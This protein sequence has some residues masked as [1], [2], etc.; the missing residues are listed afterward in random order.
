VRSKVLDV[1]RPLIRKAARPIVAFLA[2][3]AAGIAGF[4]LL[5]GVTVIE[6]TFWLLD[7]TSIELH[8]VD[9][10]VRAFALLV[11]LGLFLTGL[12][13]GETVVGAAFGGQIQ[14]ELKRVQT[15]RQLDDLSDHVIICGYGIFGRTITKTLANAGSDIVAIEQDEN[16]IDRID[17]EAVIPL[18]GDARMEETLQEAGI[19]R[20]TVVVAAIDNSNANIEI[21][22]L[23]SQLSP[24]V[25]VI[26][27]T[28]NDR[29]SRLARRAGADEVIIP[30]IASGQSVSQSISEA[31]SED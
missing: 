6:A 31:A 23:V 28:G 22:I 26:V 17:N 4:V 27:R 20:A 24:D 7:P 13:I 29:Y 12:W 3:S 14:E 5:E 15:Q 9:D 18:K 19:E 2:V 10:G 30:E 8:G 1:D 21:A 16:K 25:R 11:F